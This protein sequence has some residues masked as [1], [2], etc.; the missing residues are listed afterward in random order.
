MNGN[1][2]AGV[3]GFGLLTEAEIIYDNLSDAPRNYTLLLDLTSSE[4]G[5]HPLRLDCWMDWAAHAQTNAGPPPNN[6]YHA[7][8]CGL[9]AGSLFNIEPDLDAQWA[10][11][12]EAVG[13][14]GD[15]RVYGAYLISTD[16]ELT[17]TIGD[18]CVGADCEDSAF[19]TGDCLE[20]ALFSYR[21]DICAPEGDVE[22][23]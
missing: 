20:Q 21:S 19:Q 4:G 12:I 2:C 7:Y 1:G 13:T 5:S 23:E 17:L 15:K 11:T 9:N 18:T 8:T 6:D 14:F 3:D 16:A 10:I 22:C